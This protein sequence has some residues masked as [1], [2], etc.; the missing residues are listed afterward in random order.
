L[1]SRWLN[2]CEKEPAL[3]GFRRELVCSCALCLFWP[4]FGVPGVV[5]GRLV[6]DRE[7]AG[8]WTLPS[9]RERSLMVSRDLAR[10]WSELRSWRGRRNVATGDEGV[11]LLMVSSRSCCSRRS[12][13]SAS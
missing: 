2:E 11:V 8:P 4:G 10:S 1:T 6:Y 3:L 12:S 5:G 13:S 9:S 7:P